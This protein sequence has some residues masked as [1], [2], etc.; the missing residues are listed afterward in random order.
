VS[1]E[2]ATTEPADIEPAEPTESAILQ[3]L[4]AALVSLSPFAGEGKPVSL[5]L[6][7]KV[8]GRDAARTPQISGFQPCAVPCESLH[9]WATR[10]LCVCRLSSVQSFPPVLGNCCT[11]VILLCGTS[12]H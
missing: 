3:I 12:V 1:S 10:G 2:F 9:H 4:R 5:V 6:L 7:S 11:F 8:S